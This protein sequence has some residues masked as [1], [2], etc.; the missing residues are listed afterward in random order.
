MSGAGGRAALINLGL[1]APPPSAGHGTD[2]RSRREDLRCS[3]FVATAACVLA[4]CGSGKGGSDSSLEAQAAGWWVTPQTGDC[5][6]PP[7]PEC[8]AKDCTAYSV[9]GL[10]P[11]KRYVDG[12]VSTSSNASSMSTMGTLATGTYRVE[13]DRIIITQPGIQDLS[14][15]ATVTDGKLTLGS[16]IDV[17]APDPLAAALDAASRGGRASW[18]SWPLSR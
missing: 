5:Y 13:G 1:I 10:L 15:A 3:I 16:R 12:R 9:L 2:V 7:Q 18:E 6:C 8:A 4:A 11:D 17:R 14:L